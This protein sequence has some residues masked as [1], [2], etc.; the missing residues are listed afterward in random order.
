M[1]EKLIEIE[2]SD[3]DVFG[4]IRACFDATYDEISHSENE[5]DIVIGNYHDFIRLKQ[6]FSRFKY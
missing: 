5:V 1:Q 6:Y 2:Y 3:V 4:R